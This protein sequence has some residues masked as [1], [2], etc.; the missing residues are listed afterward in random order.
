MLGVDSYLEAKA[1]VA[2]LRSVSSIFNIS[3]PQ[4]SKVAPVVTTSSTSRICLPLI[5]LALFIL[6]GSVESQINYTIS[7]SSSFL[8]LCMRWMRQ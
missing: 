1:N 3:T 5:S 8:P 4:A 6:K 7:I 2:I